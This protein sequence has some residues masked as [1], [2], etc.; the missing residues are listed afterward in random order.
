MDPLVRLALAFLVLGAAA[1]L[2]R[3]WWRWV[4]RSYDRQE[5]WER[6]QLTKGR[7]NEQFR[8]WERE[9]ED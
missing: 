8:Q 6:Q 9:L 3:L 4:S 1:L 5:A 2:F 7:E